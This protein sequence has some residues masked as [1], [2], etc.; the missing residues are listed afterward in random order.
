[1][2]WATCDLT[3]LCFMYGVWSIEIDYAT[4]RLRYELSRLGKGKPVYS[5]TEMFHNRR[6]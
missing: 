4:E 5:F 2:K 3:L 1:M 6:Y